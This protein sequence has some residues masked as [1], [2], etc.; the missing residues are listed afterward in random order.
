MQSRG[1]MSIQDIM[2][3]LGEPPV[4]A[5]QVQWHAAIVAVMSE[6]QR[7][8]IAEVEPRW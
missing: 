8:G 7:L 6:F 3:R 2:D 5:D 4:P 1:S